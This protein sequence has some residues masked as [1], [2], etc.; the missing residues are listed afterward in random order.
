MIPGL[1]FDEGT[2]RQDLVF[3]VAVEKEESTGGVLFGRGAGDSQVVDYSCG[4]QFLHG[5]DDSSGTES[6]VVV[7]G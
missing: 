1:G 2:A 7:I 4:L 3:L 6:I 5:F